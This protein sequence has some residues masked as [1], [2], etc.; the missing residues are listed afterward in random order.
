MHI[1]Q[2][3]LNHENQKIHE[4]WYYLAVKNDLHCLEEQHQS[5]METF[6]V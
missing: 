6:R 3:N 2:N 4:K 1:S 5:M